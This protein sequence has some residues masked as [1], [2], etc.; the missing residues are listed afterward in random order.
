MLGGVMLINGY[1]FSVVQAIIMSQ[2]IPLLRYSI[3]HHALQV[4]VWVWLML[5]S[6]LSSPENVSDERI[7]LLL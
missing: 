7:A 6:V 5:T 4:L 3:I 1:D 2:A